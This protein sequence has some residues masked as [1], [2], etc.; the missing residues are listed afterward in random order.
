MYQDLYGSIKPN[1]SQEFSK[2]YERYQSKHLRK[3]MK[4]KQN[5]SISIILIYIQYIYSEYMYKIFSHIFVIY[6][7]DLYSYF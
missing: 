3:S 7:Q 5:M 2:I 6:I 4:S 1:N